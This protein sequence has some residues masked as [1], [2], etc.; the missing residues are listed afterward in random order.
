MKKSIIFVLSMLFISAFANAQITVMP[1]VQGGMSSI[2]KKPME[3]PTSSIYVES[4][5]KPGFGYAA[6]LLINYQFNRE[7]EVRTGIEYQNAGI[8][9]EERFLVGNEPSYSTTYRYAGIGTVDRIKSKVNAIYINIPI[10]FQYN[11]ETEKNIVPYI[12]LGGNL[13]WYVKD[14]SSTEGFLDN[15]FVGET[16]GEFDV[17]N[18]L[19]AGVNLDF[20]IQ[21]KINEKF[22]FNAFISGDMY[23]A[24]LGKYAEFGLNHPPFNVS[25]GVG[26][27]YSIQNN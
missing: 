14:N 10:Q 25:L 17:D 23:L 3:F 20:G 6:G 2:T 4:D 19:F 1:Y 16:D 9:V 13:S 27:A 12:A 26:L 15:E 24:R 5:Y 21:R 18:I 8:G 11:F 22:S 7:I